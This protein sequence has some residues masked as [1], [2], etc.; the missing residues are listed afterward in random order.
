MPDSI[1]D[2]LPNCITSFDIKEKSNA[3]ITVEAKCSFPVTFNGF[4]GHFPEKPILPAVIQLATIRC[5]A[6]KALQHTLSVLEYSRT[7]FKAM[8]TPDEEVQFYLSLEKTKTAVQG[9]FKI[10]NLDQKTVASG[11]YIFKRGAN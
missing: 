5:I 2:L 3:I 10:I 11:N 8:I 4:Q 7:K 1:A 6:E 9:K